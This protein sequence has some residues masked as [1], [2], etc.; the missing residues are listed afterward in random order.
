MSEATEI[1]RLLLTTRRE[2]CLGE[3]RSINLAL[4][5]LREMEGAAAPARPA[6]AE[7]SVKAPALAVQVAVD[8]PAGDTPALA[9]PIAAPPPVQRATDKPRVWTLERN[10][11]I[12]ADYPRGVPIAQIVDT[13]NALPGPPIDANRVGVQAAVLK[14]RR[15]P[16]PV[17]KPLPAPA[18]SRQQIMDKIAVTRPPATPPAV[19]KVDRA[20]M[21]SWAAQRGIQPPYDLSEINAKRAHL[22]LG[23][24]ELLPAFA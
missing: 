11:I 22:G 19:V 13:I 1:A 23:L 6:A 7:P 5:S 2:G 17:A 10:G 16:A 20:T 24:Y 14:V 9:A 8:A 3:L 4:A 18:M 12:L 15:P 21:I